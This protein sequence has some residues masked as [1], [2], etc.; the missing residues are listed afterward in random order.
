MWQYLYHSDYRNFGKPQIS[1]LAFDENTKVRLNI[2]YKRETLLYS[3]LYIG[4]RYSPTYK[5]MEVQS[6]YPT[7]FVG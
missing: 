5:Y 3:P 4:D 6:W 2:T 7:Y 1:L